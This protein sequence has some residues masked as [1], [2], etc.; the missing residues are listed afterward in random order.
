MKSKIKRKIK[1]LVLNL[2]ENKLEE[3]YLSIKNSFTINRLTK[4]I[5]EKAITITKNFIQKN[6]HK[7]KLIRLEVVGY[8]FS[9]YNNIHEK[10][11]LNLL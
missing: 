3:L 10:N 6:K 7:F 9:K 4:S 5:K 2:N 8:Y 1:L 11:I